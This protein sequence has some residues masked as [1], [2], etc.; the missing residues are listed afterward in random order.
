[1]K[2]SFLLEIIALLF[3]SN[4]VFIKSFQFLLT[5]RR[6]LNSPF[7]LGTLLLSV[8][9]ELNNSYLWYEGHT[10]GRHLN[11]VLKRDDMGYSMHFRGTGIGNSGKP[12]PWACS[13]L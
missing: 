1:M 12:R 4:D 3:G 8:H 6:Q 9:G 13:T 10:R 7:T 2:T 11:H 5:F